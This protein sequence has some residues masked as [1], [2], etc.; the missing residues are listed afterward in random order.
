MK[1]LGHPAPIKIP[2]SEFDNLFILIP[3][4]EGADVIAD[5]VLGT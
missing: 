5:Y 1:A 3:R 4:P 2:E